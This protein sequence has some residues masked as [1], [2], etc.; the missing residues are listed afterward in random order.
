ISALIMLHATLNSIAKSEPKD[1]LVSRRY[2]N[3]WILSVYLNTVFLKRAGI[4]IVN[5]KRLTHLDPPYLGQL[6]FDPHLT[7]I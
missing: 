2:D 5:A 7:F 4:I 3:I 1:Y 6:R